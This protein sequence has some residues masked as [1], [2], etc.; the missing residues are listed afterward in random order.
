MP[1]NATKPLRMAIWI[2]TDGLMDFLMDGLMDAAEC[3]RMPQNAAEC[4]RILQN[5]TECYKNRYGWPYGFL[6][7]A[8]WILTDGST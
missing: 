2:L 3:H 8:I 5:A 1:Q 4:H 7:M 6:R